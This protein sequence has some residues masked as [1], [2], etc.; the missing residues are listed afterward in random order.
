[1]LSR[2]LKTSLVAFVAM[3]GMAAQCMTI[4]SPLVVSVNVK[5]IKDTYNVTPGTINFDPGCKVKNSADYIDSKYNVSG[6][7]R[8]VDVIVK[9]NGPYT[10]QIVGG[11]IRIGA[12]PGS[13]QTLATYSGPWASFS[14]PQSL[15]QNN[16]TMT[17][18]PG[19]VNLLLSL[20]QNQQ[21]VYICHGGAFSP[22]INSGNSIDVTIYAQVNATP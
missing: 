10:G 15:I 16:V 8:L 4:T 12:A 7:G 18:N 2:L 19:G 5:D 17:L 6:G 11:Q 22:A 3:S 14:T 21:S 9:V 1:M 20:V 13:V